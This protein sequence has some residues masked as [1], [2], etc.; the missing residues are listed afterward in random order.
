[1]SN[2][3]RNLNGQFDYSTPGVEI[4]EPPKGLV[5]LRTELAKRENF[6]IAEKALREPTIEGA[7]G[8]IAEMLGIIVDGTFDM[9]W[10]CNDLAKRM[11]DRH[12]PISRIIIP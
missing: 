2:K 7:I 1:M 4:R 10:I 5:Q 3:H 11:R 8:T 6:D 9:D 12:K